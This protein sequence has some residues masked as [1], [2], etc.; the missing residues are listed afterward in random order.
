MKTFLYFFYLYIKMTNKHY[1]KN[2]ETQNRKISKTQGNTL[3]RRHKKYQNLS[4]EEKDKRRKKVGE[5]YE[6]HP[7]EQKQNLLEYII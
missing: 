7:E 4:E 3:K 1:Q 6:N 2:K 5:R